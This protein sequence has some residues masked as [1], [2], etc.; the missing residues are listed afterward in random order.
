[1]KRPPIIEYVSSLW[2]T[3][4]TVYAFGAVVVLTLLF[5]LKGSV[6]KS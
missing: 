4:V 5:R 1:V 3:D 2:P 6:Q